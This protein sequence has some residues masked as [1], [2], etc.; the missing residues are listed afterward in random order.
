MNEASLRGISDL[1]KVLFHLKDGCLELPTARY[2]TQGTRALSYGL[3]CP[4]VQGQ[5]TT[6][7]ILYLTL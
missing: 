3:N 5:G 6:G 7:A 1:N 4:W 2:K